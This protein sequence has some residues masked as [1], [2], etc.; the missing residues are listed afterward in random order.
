MTLRDLIN[1][2]VTIQGN[3][4][5]QCWVDEINP[6]IYYEGDIGTDGFHEIPEK[7]WD[8]EIT[9][10]FPYVVNVGVRVPTWVG[11]ICIELEGEEDES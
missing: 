1:D 6:D 8:R 10:I 11:A 9:Y 7:Y 2:G 3:I 5:L 4:K